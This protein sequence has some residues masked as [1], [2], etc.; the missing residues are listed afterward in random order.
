MNHI[1]TYIYISCVHTI[2]SHII[3]S[4]RP[5]FTQ[6]EPHTVSLTL[7]NLYFCILLSPDCNYSTMDVLRKETLII[8]LVA[9]VLLL[10]DPWQAANPEVTTTCGEKFPNIL[11]LAWL[12]AYLRFVLDPG[13]SLVKQDGEWGRDE[14]IGRMCSSPSWPAETNKKW[15]YHQ[16]IFARRGQD[17]A[18]EGARGEDVVN[19]EWTGQ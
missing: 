14:E 19:A 17:G 11:M 6:P 1:L 10:A 13:C 9:S 8:L 16:S 7:S 2:F 4:Q 3:H 18:A 15:F 5:C 12:K